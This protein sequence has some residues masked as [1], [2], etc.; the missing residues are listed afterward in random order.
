MLMFCTAG[1]G[2]GITQENLRAATKRR[3]Q[4]KNASAFFVLTVCSGRPGF[5]QAETGEGAHLHTL[6]RE[7]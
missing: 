7:F 6:E 4:T 5:A 1:I 2:L 3:T